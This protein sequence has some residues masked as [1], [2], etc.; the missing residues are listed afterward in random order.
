MHT[1]LLSSLPIGRFLTWLRQGVEEHTMRFCTAVNCMDG[2][3]Q[4]PVH[5]YMSSFFMADHV[6]Q[7]T[8]VGPAFHWI[9]FL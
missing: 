7:V 1:R 5:K 9:R 6:D 4:R 8:E 2:R 3:V